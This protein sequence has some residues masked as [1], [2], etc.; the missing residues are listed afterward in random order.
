MGPRELKA[1]LGELYTNC[2]SLF[3]LKGIMKMADADINPFSDHDEMDAQ[4]DKTGKTVPLNPGGGAMGGG[5]PWKP[6]QEIS[7]GG[8]SISEK[9]L[10]EHVEGLYRKLTEV[11]CQTPEA[12]HFD[13]FE[14][15]NEE[16][17]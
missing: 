6:E 2:N 15:R 14:L 8:I 11:T 7:F 17:Y 10:R 9:V 4:P 5:A 12:F 3:F 1:C 13:Y 16:L